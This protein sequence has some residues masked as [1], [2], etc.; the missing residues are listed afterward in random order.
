MLTLV[1]EVSIVDAVPLLPAIV[2]PAKLDVQ[3]KLDGLLNAQAYLTLN[4]GSVTIAAS[5]QT[6][7]DLVAGIQAAIAVGVELP[8]LSLQ[9]AAIADIIASLNI[10]LGLMALPT[11][12]G[13]FVYSYDGT[14]AA[15]GGEVAAATSGGFPGGGPGDHVNALILATALAPTWTAM[16][17]VFLTA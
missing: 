15:F 4:P 16:Q 1:G 6:A 8:S 11:E 14:A 2:V 7:L 13:V 12:A 10:Q 3:A 17:G 5:L 9:L